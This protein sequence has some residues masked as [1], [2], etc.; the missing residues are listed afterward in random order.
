MLCRYGA[1]ASEALSHVGRAR[2]QAELLPDL[3][4]RSCDGS[5]LVLQDGAFRQPEYKAVAPEKR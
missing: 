2:R 4:F 5:I 3:T 1:I